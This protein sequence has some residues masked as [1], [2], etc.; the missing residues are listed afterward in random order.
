MSQT[1]SHTSKEIIMSPPFSH[2]HKEIIMS[3]PFSHTGKEIMSRPFS[4]AGK[5]IM[6]RAFS[7]TGKEVMPNSLGYTTSKPLVVSEYVRDPPVTCLQTI[8]F[9]CWVINV[10][11]IQAWRDLKALNWYTPRLSSDLM[12]HYFV[13]SLF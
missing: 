8:W 1:F 3:P 12:T 5:E 2:T 7:H 6:S 4:H 11:I 9:V 13:S 10:I